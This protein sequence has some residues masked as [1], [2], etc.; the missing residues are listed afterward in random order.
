MAKIVLISLNL[1]D[2]SFRICLFC[3]NH[4]YFTVSLQMKLREQAA[5]QQLE[6]T[7]LHSVCTVLAIDSGECDDILRESTRKSLRVPAPECAKAGRGVRKTRE[8][9]ERK[10]AANRK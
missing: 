10:T 1:T 8:V 4:S 6:C 2:I 3:W 5:P 7:L 9:S